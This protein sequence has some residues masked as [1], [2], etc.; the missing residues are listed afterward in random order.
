MCQCPRGLVPE[1]LSIFRSEHAL[2][3][4]KERHGI[5]VSHIHSLLYPR[6]LIIRNLN[7]NAIQTV[8]KMYCLANTPEKKPALFLGQML[9]NPQW[10]LPVQKLLLGMGGGL[11][12]LPLDPS[13][14]PGREVGEAGSLVFIHQTKCL[15]LER[16]SVSGGE[17][18]LHQ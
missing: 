12:S 3:C 5:R 6:S 18:R 13:H 8:A 17:A 4:I 10:N 9:F 14:R 1:P 2:V 11:F 15:P 16:T 7:I